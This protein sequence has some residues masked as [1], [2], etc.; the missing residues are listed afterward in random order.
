MDVPGKAHCQNECLHVCLLYVC[1]AR[2]LVR[3]VAMCKQKKNQN[4]WSHVITDDIILYENWF[5][6]I[7]WVTQCPAAAWTINERVSWV[8]GGVI[9]VD[10]L[11]IGFAPSAFCTLV[12]SV[13]PFYQDMQLFI[14][15]RL[16]Q[17]HSLLLEDVCFCARWK[18]SS[19]VY[20]FTMP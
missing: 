4:V 14:F 1:L 6:W 20:P 7:P 11:I 10:A 17:W 3:T 13:L 18:S 16:E 8:P 19:L 5:C 2:E 15:H 9:L 12:V